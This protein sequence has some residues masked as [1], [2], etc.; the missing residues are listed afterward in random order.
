[1]PTERAACSSS[2]HASGH[3]CSLTS[4]TPWRPTD[5]LLSEAS[6][7]NRRVLSTVSD[8]FRETEM[9]IGLRTSGNG[10]V[11]TRLA[12]PI[13]GKSGLGGEQN[14]RKEQRVHGATRGLATD[15]SVE[16]NPE[17]GR[18]AKAMRTAG[19]SRHD[20]DRWRDRAVW[21]TSTRAA[22]DGGGRSTRCFGIC[23]STRAVL[24]VRGIRGATRECGAS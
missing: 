7:T 16:S 14:P 1:M 13:V 24:H 2:G 4:N 11:P 18:L 22:S 12:A 9:P 10:I 8:A 23:G 21:T 20:L 3:S 19:I 6:P 5:S 17:V 15:S